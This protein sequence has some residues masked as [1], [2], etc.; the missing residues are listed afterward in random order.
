MVCGLGALN[1]P[2]SV[3]LSGTGLSRM[4]TS[5]TESNQDFLPGITENDVDG[6]SDI[7]KDESQFLQ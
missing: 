1:N 6:G 3:T 4:S 5:T 2:P 7:F